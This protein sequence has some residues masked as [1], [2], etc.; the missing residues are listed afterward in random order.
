M[1]R[2]QIRE[3]AF[4]SLFAALIASGAFIRIPFVPVPLT[5][6]TFFV[7]LSAT[8]LRSRDAFFSSLVYLFVGLIGLP[9]FTTGGGIAALL[10]PT[11]G[12][13]AAL[14]ISALLSSFVMKLPFLSVKKR[15]LVSALINTLIIYSIGIIWLMMTTEISIYAALL[16]GLVP[17]IFGDA[18]KIAVTVFVTPVLRQ[19][20]DENQ[21]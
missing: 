21:I 15:A 7:M 6:Q 5:L 9:V 3:I 11:G 12:Y 13:L 10:G 17:F 2:K 4:I 1:E 18:V 20:I 8:C 19:R 14:P 16:A